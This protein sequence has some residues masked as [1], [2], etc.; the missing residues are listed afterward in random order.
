MRAIILNQ[1]GGETENMI[2]SEAPEPVAGAGEVLVAVS[3][4][5]LNFADVMMRVGTYPHPKGYPLIAGIEFAGRVVAVGAGVNTLKEGDRVA[6]FSE[7]AGGFAEYCA[8]PA[9]R[10]IRLPEAM[11]F[12]QGAAFY[13]QGLTAWHLLHTVSATRPGDVLLVHAVGGGV[14][15]HL[16]QLASRAGARVIGTVGT[17]GKEKRALQF[18]ANLVINREHEDFVS[19]VL[20]ATAGKGVDKVIDSTGASIL[21]RSFGV[22]RKL[23]HVVSYG[24]AEGRP[25]PNL[26]ERLV[27][28][29]LTFS[30]FHIGHSNFR[31]E[32]WR[33][34]AHNVVSWIAE[35]SLKLP[36][37][38]VFAF[39]DVHAMYARLASRKVSGKLL[40]RIAE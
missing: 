29:S 7:N 11:T 13:L 20:D 5:G 14:G 15:L 4:A 2:V 38:D 33:T 1:P 6:A 21:D 3:V 35:G 37:E 16:A 10:C 39:D 9:E 36:I 19:V 31:S 12:E 8:V 17:S 23:G 26:W 30:R 40:L 24:E 32:I 28:R 27:E 18:G 34:G 25:F 22:I